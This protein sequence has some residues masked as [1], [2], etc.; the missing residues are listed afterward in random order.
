LTYLL[1][2]TH[3][4][5]NGSRA[6]LGITLIQ[7]GVRSCSSSR[8]RLV[9]NV[10]FSQLYLKQRAEHPELIGLPPSGDVT[11]LD[12]S[13]GPMATAIAHHHPRPIG[14]WSAWWSAAQ[15]NPIPIETGTV[16]GLN[17]TA[18]DVAGSM[19]SAVP[20]AIADNTTMPSLTG[21]VSST[22]LAKMTASTN[23][24]MAFVLVTVGS[25]LIIGAVINYWR[26]VR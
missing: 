15:G 24:L 20:R 25:F 26:A 4:A 7:L 23:D 10:Y 1:H 3:A 9:F 8:L 2:T 19:L 5:K 16:D 14:S 18:T 12:G 22:E 21:T 6:G 11:G 13:P 17:S